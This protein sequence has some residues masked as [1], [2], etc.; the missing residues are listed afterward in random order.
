M[1]AAGR[2][3]NVASYADFLE[4]RDTRKRKRLLSDPMAPVQSRQASSTGPRSAHAVAPNGVDHRVAPSH[5]TLPN[6]SAPRRGPRV[7]ERGKGP[8][9]TDRFA[10]I[11]AAGVTG[12]L[13]IP[14]F[15][16]SSSAQPPRR[17]TPGPAIKDP[18]EGSSFASAAVP[19]SYQLKRSR[20]QQ[21]NPLSHATL[22]KPAAITPT[23]VTS[24]AVTPTA[25]T[26]TAVTPTTSTT[27]AL[28]TS[29]GGRTPAAVEKHQASSSTGVRCGLC[30]QD[31]R[32]KTSHSCL[33]CSTLICSSCIINA[34]ILHR[35]HTMNTPTTQD[36]GTTPKSL[37]P[38][39]PV[40]NCCVCQIQILDVGY[41]C[42][43]CSDAISTVN[44][45]CSCRDL[46]PDEHYLK[47]TLSLIK[48]NNN[49]GS[50]RDG[51]QTVVTEDTEDIDAHGVGVEN[52][53]QDGASV[54]DSHTGRSPR[55][56][57][58]ATALYGSDHGVVASR[59]DTHGSEEHKPQST[60]KA[61]APRQRRPSQVTFTLPRESLRQFMNVVRI[62]AQAVGCED[63]D[64]DDPDG[65]EDYDSYRL[66]DFE[67]ESL[68]GSSRPRPQIQQGSQRSRR[69]L[70]E[71][72]RRLTELKAEGWDDARIAEEL[73][74]TLGAITQQWKKQAG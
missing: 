33:D 10:P 68:E 48:Q 18:V 17:D 27:R 24:T 19:A 51:Q 73:Q 15:P 14:H 31:L 30:R 64:D 25:I 65:D 66:L 6:S 40:R 23:A 45:C 41:E 3:F 59:V 42:E 28:P 57:Q 58:K 34:P 70:P 39:T 54:H 32:E 61:I 56:P 7:E 11:R 37:R 55:V 38:T 43:D 53:E 26:S 46:H 1:F 4:V 8:Q 72:K 62:M 9:G 35:G 52:R 67:P 2:T 29:G 22:R 69:W 13:G 50:G 36:G 44:V 20:P 5:P 71:H 63:L 12:Q 60:E 21:R 74:R 16:P 47:A 49:G